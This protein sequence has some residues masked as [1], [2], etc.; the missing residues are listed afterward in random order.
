M[1]QQPFA[2]RERRYVAQQ[3]AEGLG[4]GTFAT[5]PSASMSR[6]DQGADDVTVLHH[7]RIDEDAPF[8]AEDHARESTEGNL[9]GQLKPHPLTDAVKRTLG[10][11]ADEWF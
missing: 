5:G 7:D 8:N 2:S 1:Q 11:R 4:E 6:N 3:T 9:A 10:V